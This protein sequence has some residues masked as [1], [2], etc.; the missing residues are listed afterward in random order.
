MPRARNFRKRFVSSQTFSK[1]CAAWIILLA[2]FPF[3]A[4]FSVCQPTDIM[5]VASRSDAPVQGDA[6][7]AWM[8]RGV[9]L[10]V[11]PTVPLATAVATQASWQISSAVLLGLSP[12]RQT[13]FAPLVPVVMTGEARILVLRV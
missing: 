3:T 1:F 2:L 6:S 5:G 13:P 8:M 9:E 7:E 11:E 10:G 12:L 4:P